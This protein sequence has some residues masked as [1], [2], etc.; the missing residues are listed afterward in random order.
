M[1]RHYPPSLETLL[2]VGTVMVV[3]S[4][5]DNPLRL[6][7]GAPPPPAVQGVITRTRYSGT[8]QLKTRDLVTCP[9]D[10]M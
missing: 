4:G 1:T 3:S 9:S 5:D 7:E 10:T 2:P 8:G 6:P